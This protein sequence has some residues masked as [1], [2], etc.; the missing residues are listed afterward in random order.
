MRVIAH[1]SHV[2]M[3]FDIQRIKEK[4][5]EPG[6]LF[7]YFLGK[8]NMQTIAIMSLLDFVKIKN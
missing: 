5:I 6:E 2:E 1:Q 3:T 7:F 4:K 8:I